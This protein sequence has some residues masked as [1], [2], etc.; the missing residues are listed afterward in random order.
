MREGSRA[1]HAVRLLHQDAMGGKYRGFGFQHFRRV[2]DHVEVHRHRRT[3]I[4]VEAPE[5]AAPIHR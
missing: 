4:Q 1:E 2:G 5:M 3:G